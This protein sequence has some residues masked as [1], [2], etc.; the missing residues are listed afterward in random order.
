MKWAWPDFLIS[1]A[2]GL[3]GRASGARTSLSDQLEVGLT[4]EQREWCE[5]ELAGLTN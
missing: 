4:R 1:V 2:R 5:R 3:R